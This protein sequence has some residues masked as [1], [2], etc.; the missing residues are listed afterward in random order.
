MQFN[1]MLTKDN[2]SN[3]TIS[4]KHVDWKGLKSTHKHWSKNSHM[5]FVKIES[6]RT[7]I[8]WF[9]KVSQNNLHATS[10]STDDSLS[11]N[12]FDDG[13]RSYIL[14]YYLTTHVLTKTPNV[15]TYVL[16]FVNNHNTDIIW[17]VFQQG[18]IKT[19]A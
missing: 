19:T 6:L 4:I 13:I 18:N 17:E 14:I 9:L 7:K 5:K 12:S 15:Y 16:Y 11:V 3:I 1:T 8:S 2:F 10:C